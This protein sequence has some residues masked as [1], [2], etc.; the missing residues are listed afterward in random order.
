MAKYLK[1]DC[2]LGFIENSAEIEY[3]QFNNLRHS[4]LGCMMGDFD[5]QGMYIISDEI[6]KELVSMPKYI[7]DTM[8]NLEVCASVLKLDKQLTF[9]ITYEG[10]KVTLS[11][12]EKMSYEGNAT[13]GAGTYSN[14]NE[15]VLD[16]L[17]SSGTINKNAIYSRWNIT[18]FGGSALDIFNMDEQTIAAYYNIANRFKY[19]IHAN[20]VLLE[21]EPL[22]EEIEATYANKLLAIL[23]SFPKLKEKVEQELKQV[24]EE[25]KDFIRLDKPN[26]AKTL[27][28]VIEKVIEN[29][30]NVLTEKQ[31]EKFN[32]QKHEV[33]Q[34]INEQR[35]EV[36]I[37]N[38]EPV[39][40]K[41]VVSA[42]T[43]QSEAVLDVHQ[44]E[45]V[46]ETP[47]TIATISNTTQQEATDNKKSNSQ[48][49]AELTANLLEVQKVTEQ[50][51]QAEAV[52]VLTGEHVSPQGERKSTTDDKERLLTQVAERTQQV[53]GAKK[54]EE[55]NTNS[56]TSQTNVNAKKP[57]ATQQLVNTLKTQQIDP[58]VDAKVRKTA[59]RRQREIAA[60]AEQK[61]REAER[62]AAAAAAAA[63]NNQQ[64]VNGQKGQSTNTT[65]TAPS[66]GG[67]SN[68]KGGKTG[69]QKQ[70]GGRPGKAVNNAEKNKD[71]QREER[72]EDVGYGQGGS[73]VAGDTT[74][75]FAA[76]G[77]D[78]QQ[79]GEVPAAEQSQGE[80]KGNPKHQEVAAV[81]A[82][83]ESLDENLYNRHSQRVVNLKGGEVYQYREEGVSL[84]GGG[85]SIP[86]ENNAQR[87]PSKNA[88][89][90]D[91]SGTPAAEAEGEYENTNKIL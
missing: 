20:T 37:L 26:F 34:E 6:K 32:E 55:N 39:Q 70:G 59:E 44:Q 19:L 61:R 5:N 13:L 90:L 10:E 42:H 47:H 27:N 50:R 68:G 72:K 18:E 64:A 74:G 33:Q 8:D 4:V 30:I 22:L 54:V 23:N 12:L 28:E 63:A 15:Y 86:L 79:G 57:S 17:H 51:K 77:G 7:I 58:S 65:N 82:A 16:E 11:L 78:A 21:K 62:V 36:I 71:A 41:E 56:T 48:S 46:K 14:I 29:N 80:D 3:V 2:E 9:L 67:S 75:Y 91:A 87:V 60:A 49:L 76:P 85:S 81:V 83:A 52:A 1:Q 89:K 25:K 66:G 38:V 73:G 45:N 31:Q 35:K 84:T 40:K 43:D 24:L 88:T 53:E 69:A